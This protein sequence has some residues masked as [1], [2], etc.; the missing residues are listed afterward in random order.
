MQPSSSNRRPSAHT[1]LLWCAQ[2]LVPGGPVPLVWTSF[3]TV[4][5]WTY[6][7]ATLPSKL[8][9]S[10]GTD[11]SGIP[12]SV[13]LGGVRLYAADVSG[14]TYQEPVAD[15]YRY[16]RELHL[17]SVVW[18]GI[19]PT[20]VRTSAAGGGGGGGCLR[21]WEFARRPWGGW[22]ARRPSCG[23][24]TRRVPADLELAGGRQAHQHHHRCLPAAPVDR[25]LSGERGLSHPCG[26][27][28]LCPTRTRLARMA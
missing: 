19:W 17:L 13:S 28:R 23:T 22:V 12:T 4:R 1:E 7:N 15:D 24:V 26:A 21:H 14:V 6:T 18:A 2:S 16:G 9:G 20:T 25:A 10:T 8:V 11:A 3:Y 5:C 27:A